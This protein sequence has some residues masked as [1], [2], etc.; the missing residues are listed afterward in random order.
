MRGD[1]KNI[2]LRKTAKKAGVCF[3]QIAA[4]WGVSEAYMTRFMRR[5]LTEDESRRFLD[6]VNTIASN[7]QA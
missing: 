7:E 2:N 6:A 5:D 1:L 3:W 4:L